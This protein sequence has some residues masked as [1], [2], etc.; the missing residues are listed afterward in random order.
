MERE[1]LV[2]RAAR[3]QEAVTGQLELSSKEVQQAAQ[4]AAAQAAKEAAK[5][6]ARAKAAERRAAAKEA[7]AA[8]GGS[9]GGGGA[10]RPIRKVDPKQAARLE[11][12]K[13]KYGTH[14]A[15]NIQRKLATDTSKQG[16]P[17]AA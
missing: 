12:L 13:G 3:L 11:A 1:E 2:A 15:N 4:L 6:E 5:S 7:A 14:V 8:S 16:A 9:S 17:A 10:S